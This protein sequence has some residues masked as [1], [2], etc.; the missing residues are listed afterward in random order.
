MGLTME[1]ENGHTGLKYLIEAMGGGVS[2][3]DFDRDGWPDLYCPQ[4]GSLGDGPKLPPLSDQLFL[5]RRGTEFSNVSDPA[6]IREYGYSQG[7]AAGDINE[8]GFADIVVAN[9]GRNTLF[10]NCG[11]GTFE[12]I[13]DGSG[14]QISSAMSS[15]VAMADLDGDSDLDLYVVNYVDGLKICRDDN[16][17]L[18][19]CNPAS[20]EAAAD[21]LYENLG[22][23]LFRDVSGSF[24]SGVTSGKGLGIMI[25]RLDGDLQPD[26]FVSNDTTP[27]FLF[28]NRTDARGIKLEEQGFQS[29]VAVNGKGLVQAGMGIACGDLDRDLRPDLY[30]TNF[31]R[32][33]NTLFLQRQ[34]GLFQDSTATAGLREPTLPL[35]GFG[36]QALDLD[37]DGWLE[38]FVTNGHID[39]QRKQ[40]VE[41]QMNP[42]LCRTV[43]GLHWSDISLQ[44]GPFMH[45]K[46][47]G[48]GVAVLDVNRD[49]RQDLAVGFQDRPM[50]LLVNES[51]ATGNSIVVGL[52]GVSC[53]RSATN[54][55]VYW[56]FGGKRTMTELRGGDGYYCCNERRLT[57]GLGTSELAELI[58]IHW[59]DGKVDALRNVSGNK[60]YLARQGMPLVED[61]Q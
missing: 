50:A 55:V 57:L 27:N 61:S 23:G 59:P 28:A 35:L 52:I 31:H 5:N 56:E 21:E 11:D 18:A 4:G 40:G 24:D 53:N 47:L 49:G 60:S 37:L 8:D 42:Q 20:H 46:A 39:D 17:Q 12:D 9:F 41:W 32:E 25:A 13:T 44:C 33:A 14:M 48:R 29:G 30:V 34:P 43:D 1:Y 3:V 58:E 26:I 10:L 19:T 2:I 38:L 54:A 22:N 7:V 36:T 51:S 15:S 45:Q 16:Q 6:G